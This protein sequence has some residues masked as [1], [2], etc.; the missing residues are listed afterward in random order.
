MIR[1]SDEVILREQLTPF[2]GTNG[3]TALK[4]EKNTQNLSH[5]NLLATFACFQSIFSVSIKILSFNS[6]S[7][8]TR[9][10]GRA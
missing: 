9:K 4:H 5:L 1:F 3:D 6:V 10:P 7:V 2:Y 8:F